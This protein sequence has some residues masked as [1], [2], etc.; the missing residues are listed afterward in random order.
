MQSY[1]LLKQ[2]KIINWTT[3]L[4]DDF[5]KMSIFSTFVWLLF[6]TVKVLSE[7]DKLAIILA[8][9]GLDEYLHMISMD[10]RDTNI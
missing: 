9:K 1:I 10:A 8:H 3:I 6:L 2:G 5:R 7:L 4:V